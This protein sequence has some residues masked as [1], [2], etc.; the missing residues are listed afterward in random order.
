M[1]VRLF[2]SGLLASAAPML[3]FALSSCCIADR[4]V[5][6]SGGV[7]TGKIFPSKEEGMLVI[8]TDSGVA[9]QIAKDD[10]AKET[11]S[12]VVNLDYEALLKQIPDTAE[13][14]KEIALKC[15]TGGMSEL[16]KAH[17]ERVVELNPDDRTTWSA[18]NYEFSERFGGWIRR[19]ERHYLEELGVHEREVMPLH[20]AVIMKKKLDN[21]KAKV[22]LEKRIRL[23]VAKLKKRDKDSVSAAEF[24]QGVNNPIVI[25][26]L[27]EKLMEE[28]K[29]RGN[30]EIYMQML[31]QMPGISASEVFARL[32]MN[33][34]LPDAEGSIVDQSLEALARYEASRDYASGVFIAALRSEPKKLYSSRAEF[35]AVVKRIDRAAQNLQAIPSEVAIVPLINALITTGNIVQQRQQSAGIDSTGGSGLTT[36]GSTAAGVAYEQQSVLYALQAITKVNYA[37]NKDSWRLW[38]A[39]TY[40]KSNLDL[41]RIE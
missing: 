30:W 2:H 26:F 28:L 25:E 17:Y 4:V 27:E 12:S 18:I 8:R 40:A 11:K 10:I 23:E 41:R 37:Y 6:R 36:P 33:T 29:L 19:A 14:N 20:S 32:A 34:N 5:L 35:E 3:W 24:L 39:Q 22:E 13:G 9:I 21:E 7:L 16:G 31:L 15:R 1:I 38:F